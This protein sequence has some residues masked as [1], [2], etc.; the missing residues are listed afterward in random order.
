MLSRHLV[1][2]MSRL[3]Q[4]MS[5][6]LQMMSYLHQVIS[7]LYQVMSRRATCTFANQAVERNKVKVNSSDR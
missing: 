3:Y 4:V 6:L 5:H 7:H 2:V 1:Q